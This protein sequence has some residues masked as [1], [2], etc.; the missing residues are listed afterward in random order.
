VSIFP[1]DPYRCT[2]AGVSKRSLVTVRPSKERGAHSAR[3]VHL[4]RFDVLYLRMSVPED[5]RHG[6][7]GEIVFAA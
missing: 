3:A 1:S 5:V 4:Q 7:V 6:G 2:V